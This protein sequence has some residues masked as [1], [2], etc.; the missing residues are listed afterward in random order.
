M[1]FEKF[2][3]QLELGMLGEIALDVHEGARHRRVIPTVAFHHSLICEGPQGL[4]VA[5]QTHIVE[6]L[7]EGDAVD[8][9][10]LRSGLPVEVRREQLFSYLSV[11]EKIGIVQEGSKVIV[12]GSEARILKIDQAQTSGLEHEVTAVVIAMGE[13]AGLA[14]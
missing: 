2:P 3:E 1:R 11:E 5:L 12:A 10:P 8:G 6:H 9:V 7:L 4:E 14:R 13:D